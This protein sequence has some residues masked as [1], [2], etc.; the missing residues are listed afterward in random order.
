MLLRDQ[1]LTSMRRT[2]K[3]SGEE[4]KEKKGRSSSAA[5][6]EREEGD[7]FARLGSPARGPH[8]G[9][10]LSRASPT[11]DVLRCRR[12]ERRSSSSSSCSAVRP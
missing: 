1:R 7:G 2:K 5:E 9:V 10:A 4:K 6:A 8:G 11:R 12:G 3:D